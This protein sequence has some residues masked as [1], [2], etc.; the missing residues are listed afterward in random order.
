[1]EEILK[2]KNMLRKF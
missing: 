2:P 1:M